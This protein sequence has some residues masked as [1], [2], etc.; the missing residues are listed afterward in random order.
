MAGTE[1]FEPS[2][3]GFG[4]RCSINWAMS[5]YG[6]QNES[7]THLF[8]FADWHLTAWFS[9][10]KKTDA[11]HHFQRAGRK[12]KL[13]VDV[14]IKVLQVS[15]NI[16]SYTINTSN[17]ERQGGVEPPPWVWK[18]QILT[19][20][21]LAQIIQDTFVFYRRL[22]QIC[23]PPRFVEADGTR[24]HKQRFPIYKRKLLCVS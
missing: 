15:L 10:H 7:W 14:W 1:G 2:T 4:D 11:F 9:A 19:A 5:L 20:I 21:R 16:L 23:L 17:M 18:T 13:A 22:C 8:S 6:G 3:R 24:T 12:R